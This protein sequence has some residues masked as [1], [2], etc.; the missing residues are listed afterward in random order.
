MTIR[1]LTSVI[2]LYLQE[3][4]ESSTDVLKEILKPVMD[5]VEEIS[6]PPRD[7]ESL[8]L[9]EKVSLDSTLVELN[10]KY[11]ETTIQYIYVGF[12]RSFCCLKI[13]LE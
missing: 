10:F 11:V 13:F 3:K 1:C 6:W 7:P 12:F 4:I 2:I 9:M 5:E 8:I